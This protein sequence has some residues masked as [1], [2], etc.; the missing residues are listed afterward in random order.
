[1]EP[2]RNRSFLNTRSDWQSHLTNWQNLKNKMEFANNASKTYNA[3]CMNKLI[4]EDRW[5]GWGKC[6]NKTY[7]PYTRPTTEFLSFTRLPQATLHPMSPKEAFWVFSRQKPEKWTLD[8][9]SHAINSF[10]TLGNQESFTR[11]R[12]PV[13]LSWEKADTSGRQHHSALDMKAW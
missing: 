10:W 4:C 2:E 8:L 5:G 3:K 9:S 1:M 13:S 12:P 11:S 6:E 7:M